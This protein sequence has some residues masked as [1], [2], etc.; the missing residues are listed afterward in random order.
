M[1]G[2][3]LFQ[4]VFIPGIARDEKV[5]ERSC[6]NTFNTTAALRAYAKILI[7]REH[8][9]FDKSVQVGTGRFHFTTQKNIPPGKLP[10]RKRHC[11]F[12]PAVIFPLKISRQVKLISR[13]VIPA[14][15]KF[16]APFKCAP[17]FKFA[18]PY[19]NDVQ[20]SMQNA[21]DMA[22]AVVKLLSLLQLGT[23]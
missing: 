12:I 23:F 6:K 18:A 3:R 10:A 5:S 9:N 15:F 1:T 4:Q 19:S 7:G 20:D 8:D 2:S 16:P 21:A 17:P 14:P 22:L 13:Q 11:Q